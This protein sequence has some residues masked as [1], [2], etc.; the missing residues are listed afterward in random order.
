MPT[1]G[2]KFKVPPVYAKGEDF[3]ATLLQ[4]CVNG[5]RASKVAEDFLRRQEHMREWHMRNIVERLAKASKRK[6]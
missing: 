4:K 5:E 2:P 3:R 6:Q 1:F